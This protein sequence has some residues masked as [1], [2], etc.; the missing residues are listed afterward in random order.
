[1]KKNQPVTEEI[2]EEKVEE[3]VEEAV[4]EE[5]PQ[6]IQYE[7]EY[8]QDIENSRLDF[9]KFY[10]TQNI[11]K[12][13]V[14][15][16]S[17]TIVL[18]DF[19]LIP[20]LFPEKAK[21]RLALM[22]VI[23]GVALGGA[24]T[25][26]ILIKRFINKRMKKYFVDYYQSVDNYVFD[27]EGF[28]DA[29]LQDPDRIEQVQFDE[30]KI[31]VNV[32]NV[33]SRGLTTFRF[34]DKPMYICDCAAQIRL[35]KS[36]KPVFVGKY[37]VGDSTYED[38][39]PVIIYIKGDERSLPPTNV[40]A[41]KLVYDDKDMLVYSNNKDWNKL[42]NSKLMKKLHTF[43]L[44]K[45]LVD[46]TISFVNKKVYMCLGYDDSLMVLPLQN[47]FDPKPNMQYKKDL[48]Y[49]ASLIE[50]LDK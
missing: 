7:S 19:L 50:E 49:F 6:P 44:S 38:A 17:L 26:T 40:E 8:L 5:A 33:G 37:L 15:L 14:A 28:S 2:K 31:H 43:K 35:E 34:H 42:V 20:N 21:L 32:S 1:M 48:A 12:W 22:L 27:Q 24:G 46:V 39:D 36:M 23:A 9:L 3:P 30:N 10:K 11:F 41:N 25:Y 18:L 13:I 29:E 16:V 47:P 4:V 45:D